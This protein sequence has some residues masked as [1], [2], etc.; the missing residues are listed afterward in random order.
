MKWLTMSQDSI[1]G[2]GGIALSQLIPDSM[3]QSLLANLTQE[4]RHQLET[5]FDPNAPN[6]IWITIDNVR[7]GG[8]PGMCHASWSGLTSSYLPSF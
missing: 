1:P 7:K 8:T 2:P 3:R 6:N 5:V 4:Q